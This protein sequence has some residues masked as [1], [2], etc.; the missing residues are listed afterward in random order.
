MIDVKR[1]IASIIASL[2]GV[3]VP[4]ATSADPPNPRVTAPPY[5]TVPASSL[6]QSAP[7][8]SVYELTCD[9]ENVGQFTSVPAL[10]QAPLGAAAR[11]VLFLKGGRSTGRAFPWLK[12][13]RARY[14][15]SPHACELVGLDTSGAPRERYRVTGAWPAMVSEGARLGSN[16]TYDVQMRFK[17]MKPIGLNRSVIDPS[18]HAP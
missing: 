9:G 4:L 6:T 13:A 14:D 11:G 17:D 1:T 7:A 18:R 3:A 16:R 10:A 5:P 2:V 8:P 12:W 15:E